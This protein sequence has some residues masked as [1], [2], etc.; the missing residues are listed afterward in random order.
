M[1]IK[2]YTAII[3]ISLTVI[4]VGCGSIFWRSSKPSQQNK[5]SVKFLDV[6][7]NS[8]ELQDKV[9]V[10]VTEEKD[11][12]K[13]VEL[14]LSKGVLSGRLRNSYCVEL[15]DDNIFEGHPQCR[16]EI[17][18]KKGSNEKNTY[19][20]GTCVLGGK[21]YLFYCK[22]TNSDQSVEQG[23]LFSNM[24]V[25][26]V[27]ILSCGE[28]IENMSYMFYNCRDLRVLWLNN[29]TTIYV[30]NMSYMF[31]GCSSLTSLNLSNFN[32]SKVANMESMFY[33]CES[34]TKL[35]LT[36]F[37]V[38]V[39]D[40][41][42]HLR[43]IFDEYCQQ[44]VECYITCPYSVMVLFVSRGIVKDFTDSKEIQK[45]AGKGK[46]NKKRKSYSFKC[47]R[48]GNNVLSVLDYKQD[49]DLTQ[50]AS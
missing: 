17:I 22:D 37:D 45:D 16:V 34:L 35:N 19:S 18:C 14:I 27:E 3:I 1:E 47:A 30:T 8:S 41:K 50:I 29:L 11:K 49:D 10:V 46:Y 48:M 5:I 39:A 32:T 44:D 12:N 33:G 15:G 36:N 42:D 24:S 38:V 6:R 9:K 23:G 4:F 25:C 43:N 31:S 26:E 2:K 13:V 21:K 7:I 20:L 40:G 28:K